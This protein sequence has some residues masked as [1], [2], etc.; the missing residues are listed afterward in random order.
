MLSIVQNSN[1]GQAMQSI[2]D[3][4]K[5]SD[6][7]AVDADAARE[8]GA[9]CHFRCASTEAAPLE[10]HVTQT[11]LDAGKL[12]DLPS[13]EVALHRAVDE[14][15]AKRRL[16]RPV[17]GGGWAI[18]DEHLDDSGKPASYALQIVVRRDADNRLMFEPAEHPLEAEIGAA[19]TRHKASYAATDISA[20]LVRLAEQHDAVSPR[21]RGGFYFVPRQTLESFRKWSRAVHAASGSRVFFIPAMKSDEAIE[22]ILDAIT[23]E[24]ESAAEGM[25][26]ALNDHADALAQQAAIEEGTATATSPLPPAMGKRAIGSKLRSLTKLGGKLSTYEELLDCRLDT[27]RE[28]LERVRAG[29]TVASLAV[30]DG[31]K[32]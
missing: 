25:E 6:F 20:W 2:K 23:R 9:I 8:A 13:A 3:P 22:A 29:L 7:I 26:E 27:I 17:E 18:V 19:Y 14:Q 30:E 4:L 11:G 1:N 28:R 12:P 5:D 21:D 16:V 15:R 10:H 24:A 32:E 31:G